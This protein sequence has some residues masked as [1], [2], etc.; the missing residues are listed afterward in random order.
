M[1]LDN[2]PGCKVGSN[3]SVR[4]VMQFIHSFG[5]GDS[6]GMLALATVSP[7]GLIFLGPAVLLSIYS[8]LF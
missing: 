3:V 6:V 8:L 7:S 1:F 5:S 2:S 4:F